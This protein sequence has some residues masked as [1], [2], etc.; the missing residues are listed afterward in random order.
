MDTPQNL[1]SVGT[2]SLGN[3]PGYELQVSLDGSFKFVSC[4][5]VRNGN[6]LRKCDKGCVTCNYIGKVYVKSR[7]TGDLFKPHIRNGKNV[8]CTTKGVVYCITCTCCGLQ[9]VGETKRSVHCRFSEHRY[10][11]KKGHT[12][13]AK[14]F[15][16]TG[17]TVENMRLT[18][19]ELVEENNLKERED[20]WIRQLI[21]PY[22]FGLNDKIKGYGN[23][24]AATCYDLKTRNH[25]YFSLPLPRKPRSHGRK[26]RRSKR[27]PVNVL[28]N[29]LN[30]YNYGG[31]ATLYTKLRELN[32]KELSF[33]S[34]ELCVN[35]V[36]SEF[37]LILHCYVL[38]KNCENKIKQVNKQNEYVKFN[39]PSRGCSM[40]NLH[41]VLKD[42]SL[43]R[44]LP[45]GCVSK[46]TVLNLVYIYN[47]PLSRQLYNYSKVLK[48]LTLAKLKDV[49][50]GS[51]ECVGSNFRY[52]PLS[53][54]MT[55]DNEFISHD[56]LR[57]FFKKGAKYREPKVLNWEEI[58]ESAHIGVTALIERK[59]RK[60]SKQP[61]DFQAFYH[62]FMMIV[63]NRISYFRGNLR[64]SIGNT[65]PPL[66][67]N[68][69]CRDQLR[70]LHEHFVIVPADKASNN[71]VY[72]CKKLY[73]SAI[74]SELGIQYDIGANTWKF[75]GNITYRLTN[76]LEESIINRHIGIAATF[77]T[78]V[79]L[80]DRQ[81]PTLFATAKMHK[82]PHKFRY[83]AGAKKSS[84]KS[85]SM[86]THTVL[87]HFRNHLKAYCNASIQH[88]GL[89]S[90]WSINK[91]MDVVSELANR[92]TDIAATNKLVSVDFSTLFT[93]LPHAIIYKNL[94]NLID[95]LFQNSK[96]HYIAISVFRKKTFYTNDTDYN[97]YTYLTVA[98][99]KNLIHLVVSETYVKFGGV[100]FKQVCGIPMGGSASPMIADLT[101][102]ALEFDFLKKACNIELARTIH[103]A[104]RYIDDLCMV[105]GNSWEE[106]LK[107]IYPAELQFSRTNTED[108]RCDFLDLAILA[109]NKYS[110]SVYD[111][112]EDFDFTVTKFLFED[113]N[114]SPA[115][116][117]E[118][119]YAQL[120]RHAR[121]NTNKSDFITKARNMQCSLMRHG[122]AKSRLVAAFIRFACNQRTLLIKYGITNKTHLFNIAAKIFL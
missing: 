61:A 99:V 72:I 30:I 31:M 54:V 88:S 53:H 83:I 22:P 23:V 112:T 32:R 49:V 52:T 118:V 6:A 37:N 17:H 75:D 109:I 35:M 55:G 64:A 76:E 122:F 120:V 85:I 90:F 113:S 8:D 65:S 114:V 115:I 87:L 9:Y 7:T 63:G 15:R 91:S 19:L 58:V 26:R 4:V 104:Y 82:Q 29:L 50:T 40:I 36:D 60:L 41:T 110:F 11:I 102:A 86:L 73:L 69:E 42:K 62:R 101:L 38:S 25:P 93:S 74:A 121:I 84:T 67:F 57:Q 97:G 10:S 13:L 100:I 2:V 28:V 79:V 116:G 51:C 119:F 20:F 111:K 21:T 12:I 70:K 92:N 47:P 68:T 27:Q 66:K 78:N 39:Y 89:A 108:D 81:I 94:F 96:K 5:E 24:G 117:Y 3:L 16:K 1:L 14:H 46:N 77:K 80:E 105:A 56:G 33:L 45:A 95:V 48:N 18:V 34:Q 59:C 107:L 44:L 71:Y 103:Y 98:D 43:L 106:I